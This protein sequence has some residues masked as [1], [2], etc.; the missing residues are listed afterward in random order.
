VIDV[1]GDGANNIGRPAERARDSAVEA[2]IMI[3]GLPILTLEPNLD[4]YYRE[5]VIGGAGAFV[6]AVDNYGQFAAAIQRKL[7]TEIA[8]QGTSRAQGAA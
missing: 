1:S 4:V 3:N 8:A 7:I 2:G 6:I 5:S